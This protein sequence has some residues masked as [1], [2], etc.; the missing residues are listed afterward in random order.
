NGLQNHRCVSFSRAD[1]LLG[2]L[3]GTVEP[4]GRRPLLGFEI[5]VPAAHGKTVFF[6]DDRVTD[7]VDIHIHIFHHA[8]DSY[9]LLKVFLSKYSKMGLYSVEQFAH[10]GGDTVK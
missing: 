3:Q 1:K 8:P 10:Y 6:P 5:G 7:N 2:F 9:E 4:Q